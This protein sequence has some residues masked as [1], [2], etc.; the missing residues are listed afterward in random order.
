[1]SKDKKK[2]KPA[3]GEAAD[4]MTRARDVYR[5]MGEN[6]DHVESGVRSL[7]D[8]TDVGRARRSRARTDLRRLADQCVYLRDLTEVLGV[9]LEEEGP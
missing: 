5:S 4:A 9:A 2:K 6:V 8:E 7:A 1:M 3:A